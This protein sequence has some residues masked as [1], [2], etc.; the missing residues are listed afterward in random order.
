MEDLEGYRK[1]RVSIEIY[2]TDFQTMVSFT[3]DMSRLEARQFIPELIAALTSAG[4][5]R[6]DGDGLYRESYNGGEPRDFVT[7]RLED[8]DRRVLIHVDKPVD[9]SLPALNE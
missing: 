3:Y 1:N 2:S 6:A 9:L 7:W 5:R 8:R 4:L